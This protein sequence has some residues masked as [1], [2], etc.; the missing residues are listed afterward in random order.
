M[1]KY[2]LKQLIAEKAFEENRKITYAD[3]AQG[4]GLSKTTISKIAAERGY[5][6]AVSNIERICIYFGC[7]LSEFISIV[8]DDTQK[9]ARG[10]KAR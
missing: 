10:K 5:D 3:V 4:T 1:I 2:N 9:T 6:T 8:P 7:A